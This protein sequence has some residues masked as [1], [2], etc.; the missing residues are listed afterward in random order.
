MLRHRISFGPASVAMSLGTECAGEQG[1]FWS[2][3]DARIQSG[4]GTVAGQVSLAGSL[5]L[6]VPEFTACMEEKRYQ[7]FLDEDVAA[8]QA[9]GISYQPAFVIS[10]GGESVKRISWLTADQLGEIIDELLN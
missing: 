2:F 9:N 3:H 5:G 7:K 8:A 1:A 10:G 6:D 4:S